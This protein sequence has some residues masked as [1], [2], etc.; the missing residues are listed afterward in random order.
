MASS[1]SAVTVP[2]L[3]HPHAVGQGA[4]QVARHEAQRTVGRI[5]QRGLLRLRGVG[6]HRHHDEQ[7]HE[8]D[9][10]GPDRDRD[11]ELD[12]REAAGDGGEGAHQ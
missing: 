4:A 10:D 2:P 6:I 9:H 5:D 3:R 7:R 1:S 12:E 11:D 8:G